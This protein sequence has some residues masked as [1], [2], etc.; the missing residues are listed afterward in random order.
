MTSQAVVFPGTGYVEVRAVQVWTGVLLF[1]FYE[2]LA[3]NG[4]RKAFNRRAGLRVELQGLEFLKLL[5]EIQTH[6]F[7]RARCERH[8]SLPS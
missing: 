7:I 2:T 1:D 3:F 6:F 5:D 8:A 4:L